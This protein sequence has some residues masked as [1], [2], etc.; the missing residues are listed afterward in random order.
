[1]NHKKICITRP[2]NE[3]YTLFITMDSTLINASM[4]STACSRYDFSVLDVSKD[5]FEC[6]LIQLEHK[7]L[8]SNNDFIREISQLTSSFNK[9]F[10]ELHLRLR[11]NGEILKVLNLEL[12]QAKWEQTKK[13]MQKV[14][15]NNEE[16]KKVLQLNDHLFIHPDKIKAGIK[17][18][19]FFQIYFGNYFDIQIPSERCIQGTNIL[20]TANIDWKVSLHIDK[21]ADMLTDTVTIFSEGIPEKLNKEFYRSAYRAFSDK[22]NMKDL[23]T[24]LYDNATVQINSSTGRLIQAKVEK[25]EIVT[26]TLYNKLLYRLMCDDI[27]LCELN[28]DTGKK[29]QE[30]PEKRAYPSNYTN[31]FDL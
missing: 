7:L 22:I 4:S 20:N 18:I 24:E 11:H 10:N 19:E 5:Y 3:Q 6:R 17:A 14:A 31:I 21:R 12:I 28:P 23:T 8:E 29:G 30:T 25:A 13:E 26:S 2:F 27:Y 9:M 15:D 16:V 1:M